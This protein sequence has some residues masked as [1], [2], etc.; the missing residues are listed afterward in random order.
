MTMANKIKISG[1]RDGREVEL[2]QDLD[3]IYIH[4]EHG[5]LYIDLAGQVPGTVLMRASVADWQEQGPRRLI[6]SPM[7]AQ[8]MSVGVIKSH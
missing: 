2:P 4:L 7:D 3:A 5:S 8:R 1:A 6:F